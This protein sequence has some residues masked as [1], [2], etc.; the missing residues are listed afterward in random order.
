[1]SQGRQDSEKPLRISAVRQE[2]LACGYRSLLLRENVSGDSPGMPAV[3]AFAHKPFDARTACIAI[4]E[5]AERSSVHVAS[6]RSI[7]A[8]VVFVVRPNG[9]EW[10]QQGESPR[11]IGA[12]I[13]PD[14]VPGFF[15]RH[16]DDFA[17]DAI[18]RAKTWARFDV[19]YQRTFVDLGLM[20]LVENQIG[21]RLQDLIVNNVQT[22]KEILRWDTLSDRQG[23]WLLKSV[24]WLVAAKILGD[25]NVARFGDVS[26]TNVEEVLDSVGE[27]CGAQNIAVGGKD[28][29]EA[30]TEVA[31]RIAA[32]S[33]L[34]LA[35]TE[36]LAH[37]YENALISKATR[38]AL[39]THSTP[40]YLVDYIL[41][42]LTPWIQDI[43]LQARNVF[44]PAC[45]HA[46]F[47][48]SVMRLLTELHPDGQIPQ[49]R[50]SYLRKRLHGCE[51]DDFALEIARLSLS[52]TDI[53]NPNGWDLRPGDMFIGDTL[54][55]MASE[56]TILLANP[57][58]ENFKTQEKDWYSAKRV[59]LTHINKT[60]EMLHRTLPALP[61]GAV[62]GLVVPQGFLT[63]QNATNVRKLLTTDFDLQEICL[64]P[65]KVFTFSDS[66][67]AVLTARKRRPG[68]NQ[69]NPVRY[70]RVRERD[71]AKF[72]SEYSVTWDSVVQ[73]SEFQTDQYQFQ[74]ADLKQI[75]AEC[76]QSMC[77]G[78]IAEIGQGMQYKGK[79]LPPNAVTISDQRFVGSVSGFV[80]FDPRLLLHTLPSTKWMSLDRSLILR[81]SYG[82]TVGIP[83]II[84]NEARV[85]RGPWRI[86][87]LL[88]YSG[89]PVTRR[90][91]VVRANEQ[92]NQ[93]LELFWALCNSPIANAFAYDMA[94]KRHNDAGMMRQMPVPSLSKAKIRR[95]VDAVTAYLTFVRNH[96]DAVLKSPIDTKKARVL[97]LR[98][99]CEVLKL[100]DLPKELERQLLD[101]F[102]GWERHGVPF[103][104]ERYFP[105]HF[106]DSISLADYLAITEDWPKT[107]RRRAKLIEKK[108]D[109]T[110]STAETAELKRLQSLA[111]SR[112]NLVA[113]LPQAELDAL[114]REVVEEI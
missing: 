78:Q 56:A 80:R 34:E 114:H 38:Q 82:T 17:P 27:H 60:A 41:G 28:R 39:G 46:A 58:F 9:L 42:Q 94:G 62:V 63:H 33:S 47:L 8:P 81:E 20:P 93:P 31:G 6:L 21:E 95:V 108:V 75:W 10:W 19:Q 4:V 14:N 12:V 111:T 49:K 29:G 101:Y 36:S 15:V 16:R 64:F 102:A 13:P 107:N 103:K 45:G 92:D 3:V 25:K 69:N 106:T 74:L 50:R 77:F 68:A 73:S 98:V 113:P 32:F 18:Y 76:P 97:L 85:S 23:A 53:P 22:L 2:V 79:D 54:E 48:V 70:R 67:S 84:F 109:R 104:F 55:T 52:L 65:D 91:N 90:F 100:Y 26:L 66:E 88:D 30:L 86:K 11:Q 35:T 112:R 37:V 44:E 83:Q 96:D 61:E 24:F 72:A 71:M 57:P 59:E 40:S 89:H 5:G 51:I 43:D 110:I 1:M 99:D 7:A 105:E 87:A